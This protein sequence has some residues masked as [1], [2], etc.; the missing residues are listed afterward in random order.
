MVWKVLFSMKAASKG[1][2]GV[3][4]FEAWNAA[5]GQAA[6]V[7][8]SRSFPDALLLNQPLILLRNPRI[9]DYLHAPQAGTPVASN[10]IGQ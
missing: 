4:A 10:S 2:V 3:P 8:G 1:N 5:L 6:S 9:G 7:V